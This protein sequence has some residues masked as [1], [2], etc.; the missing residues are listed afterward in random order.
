MKDY[1]RI[2]V[3][4][5]LM[6]VSLSAFASTTKVLITVDVES[7]EKGNPDKQI[8][9][10]QPDGEHGI[11]RIMDLLDKHHLKGTFYLNVYEAAKHGEPAIAE[12]ARL[13]HERGHDL[14][15]H[16][17][18]SPMFKAYSMQ[19]AELELQ[20]EILKRGKELIHE[21]TGK[22]V[23]AHRAGAFAGNL[24]TLKASQI[25]GLAIDSS[26]SPVT[27]RSMLAHQLEASNLPQR[28]H[29]VVELPITFYTQLR[30]GDWQSL[31]FLDVE[32]TS[33]GEFK[34]V[35]RQFRDAGF[36]VA[37]IVMHSFSFVRTGAANPAMERRFDELL[38]FLAQEPG[39]EVV[40][41]SQLHPEW[42][43]QVAV[44][45][46]GP[47]LVPHTGVWL[48]YWRAVEHMGEGGANL[49]L[50]LAPLGLAGA[51]ILAMFLWRRSAR[52]KGKA[53]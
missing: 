6:F 40:T 53:A 50:A 34:S 4:L 27:Q 14:Q 23:V 2:Y 24:Q 11:R 45:E 5:L 9:G 32:A 46:K 18:P 16:T 38:A 30:F 28:I 48:T 49:A 37:N 1:Y 31:R 15:L 12:V 20:V 8:W 52:P 21:W 29:G 3:V 19:R 43:A 41:V 47:D 26:F 39:I 25:T 35:I 33:L 17:H 36:P 22:T 42:T 7:Y 10:K 44:L 13:I 51:A